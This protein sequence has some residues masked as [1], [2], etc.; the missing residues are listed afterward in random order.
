M[1]K[2]NFQSD[3]VITAEKI[4]QDYEDDNVGVA[5]FTCRRFGV[6][7][8][9]HNLELKVRF[10]QEKNGWEIISKREWKYPQ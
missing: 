1:N 2:D 7:S 6:N 9:T 3:W 8:G 5:E 10:N 4:Y